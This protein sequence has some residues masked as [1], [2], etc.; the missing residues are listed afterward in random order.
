VVV[1]DGGI[2]TLSTTHVALLRAWD[3]ELAHW[4]GGAYVDYLMDSVAIAVL[5]DERAADFSGSPE[6]DKEQLLMAAPGALTIYPFGDPLSGTGIAEAIPVVPI[7]E[8]LEPHPLG[9]A[10]WMVL[11]GWMCGKEQEAEAAFAACAERYL[12]LTKLPVEVR[13]PRVFAGSVRNGT[14]HA[15]GGESLV[16]ALL[17]D[18]GAEYIF[19]GTNGHENV[20]VPLEEM[21]ALAAD[22]DAWGVVWH[23]P[24]GLTM[25]TLLTADERHAWLVPE[26]VRVFGANTASCDYFGSW[27]AAPDALLEN[28]IDLFH[29]EL[30]SER[31]GEGCFEWLTET[32]TGTGTGTG[33]ELSL[34]GT[35]GGR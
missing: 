8:Y 23:A 5:D 19:K 13:R 18:A 31:P 24:E 35:G 2:A 17:Q 26:G 10:E 28:L 33:G 4:A 15:P 25:E 32:G 11:F 6:I 7:G 30:L 20:E 3:D 16:A 34:A 9:R 12:A 29:P 21:F 14:W 22:A 27:V 1:G